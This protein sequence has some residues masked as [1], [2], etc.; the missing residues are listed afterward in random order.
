[1]QKEALNK[2]NTTTAYNEYN[3]CNKGIKAD[4]D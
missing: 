4:E 1:L 3:K 2:I